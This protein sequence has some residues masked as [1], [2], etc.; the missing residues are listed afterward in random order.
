MMTSRR[1]ISKL[2]RNAHNSNF[3]I[4]SKDIKLRIFITLPWLP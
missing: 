1:R 2:L 3:N 4:S